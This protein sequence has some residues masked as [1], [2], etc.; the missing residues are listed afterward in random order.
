LLGVSGVVFWMTGQT[1]YTLVL[2]PE[3]VAQISVSY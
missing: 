3:G 2:A 1:D